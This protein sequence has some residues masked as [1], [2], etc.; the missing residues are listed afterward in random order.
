M[1][2]RVHIYHTNDIHSHLEN[3]PR[4]HRFLKER[5]AAHEAEGE[6]VFVF[7]C[8]DFV[9]R[10]HPF[11]E[12]TKGKGNVRLLNE[13]G[14]TAVTIGNNEGMTLDHR[15][16]DELYDDA[17]FDVVLANLFLPEG[18]RPAWALPRRMYTTS[19]GAKIGVT[20]VT[21]HYHRLY[22][23]LDWELGEPLQALSKQID[24]LRHEADVIIVLSHLGLQADQWIAENEPAVD[25]I[26]GG[27]THHVLPSGEQA[28]EAILGAAGRYGE[29]VG[30]VSAEWEIGDV[31]TKT[32]QAA[33]FETAYL[34]APPDETEQMHEWREIG[35][36]MLSAEVVSLPK[37]LTY[38]WDKRSE[39]PAMLSEALYHWCGADCALV[40]SGL[41]LSRLD[42]GPVT[43]Y[44]IHRMLPHPINPCKVELTGEE[45][46]EVLYQAERTHLPQLKFQGLGFRG[47]MMGKFIYHQI[48]ADFQSDI[49]KIGGK[50][51][52]LEE[53]YEIATLDMF[54]FG[55]FFPQIQHAKA[56]TYYLPE[57]LRDVM[58]W[59]L[60]RLYQM[61]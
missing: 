30:Y 53:T 21:A 35:K 60:I 56:K 45:L 16:L 46:K 59:Y 25:L 22:N 29:Y 8:G 57:F 54:T 23:L 42:E 38:S 3:W 37:P 36:K 48:A 39:L 11:T 55:K 58:E 52:D 12:G 5:K 28:G 10:W 50:P 2:E 15:S 33:L 49:I 61:P 31:S 9:D 14:Y 13:A 34:A 41:F 32:F 40:N 26:L 17:R 51:L 27:H 6:D 7:D 47:V 24:M 19:K 20:G 18:N 44:D 4:I 1:K 43:K